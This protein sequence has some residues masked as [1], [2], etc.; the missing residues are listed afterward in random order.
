MYGIP[1]MKLDKRIV[2]R[3]IQLM[4]EEGVT[5]I[6]NTQVGESISAKQL[7]DAYDAVI[8]CCALGP[9]PGSGCRKP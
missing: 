7:L 9:S 4:T 3:R 1:N 2:R 6:T 8:L 5:F